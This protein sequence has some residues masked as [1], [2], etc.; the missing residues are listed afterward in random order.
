MVRDLERVT[1][2]IFDTVVIGGG[3]YGAA[4]ARELAGRGLSVVVVERGDFAAATSFNSLKTIHGGIRA[5]QHGSLTVMREFVRERRGIAAIAPHLVR[6]LPFVIP[7]TRRVPRNPA[8]MRAFLSA[9]DLLSADR[10]DGIDPSR[11]LPPSRV[12]SRNDCL[13]LNPWIDP[14]GVTGG[15]LW[16][17]YQLHSPERFA[18]GLLQ[19]A[20]DKGAA[21]LNYAEVQALI[22]N[23]RQIIGIRARDLETGVPFD[24]RARVVVNAAGPWAAG[25]LERLGTA[26]AT[27]PRPAWSL[28]MNVVLDRPAPAC[29][30]GGLARGRFLFLVPWQ[31]Q[32]IV[33]TSHDRFRGDTGVPTIT[34]SHVDAF[35][36]DAVA[37]FPGAGLNRDAVRLVHRG[38]LPAPPRARDAGAL[39]KRSI[40]HD[41]AADGLDGLITVIGVRYTTA[42][43][44]AA[45]VAERVAR[46]MGLPASIAE[47]MKDPL[48]GGHIADLEQYESQHVVRNAAGLLL[49]ASPHRGVR[50]QS[51]GRKPPPDG[52]VGPGQSA[53]T[54]V[55]RHSRGNPLLGP[56]GD[57]PSSHGCPA[58]A[59]RGRRRR[60]SRHRCRAGRGRRHGE[61][62]VL[63]AGSDRPRNRGHESRLRHPRSH[64]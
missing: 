22:R 23:G 31:N 57:G 27:G 34:G 55:R 44:T 36:A 41:H 14:A 46:K 18:M 21:T 24:I 58:P 42:R 16:H 33:G 12:I 61:R 20:V 40:I 30:A 17:D 25:L 8:V 59:H 53:R 3:V 15:A 2:G 28:A 13:H 7:T 10:N 9:Y 45:A 37:A 54:S 26:A 50:N 63:D 4:A 64:A 5:L 11:R 60:S 43:A 29:A 6:V 32:S 62:A 35:L 56:L 51:R 39:L 49:R 52:V 38:L 19:S 1:A 48:P 47:P